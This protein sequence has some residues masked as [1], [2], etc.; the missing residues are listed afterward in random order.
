MNNIE[1]LLEL[2]RIQ[3]L[4]WII[5]QEATTY[6]HPHVHIYMYLIDQQWS[7]IQEWSTMAVI[8]KDVRFSECFKK[9]RKP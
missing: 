6:D 3:N 4:P 2:K 5:S 7:D 1:L 9:V 8:S